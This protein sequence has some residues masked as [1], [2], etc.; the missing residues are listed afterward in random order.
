[1]KTVARI[2]GIISFLVAILFCVLSIHRAE[3]D[4]KDI[5]EDLTQ[6]NSQIEQFR[7]QVKGTEGETKTYLDGELAKAEKMIADSPKESTY[8]IVQIFI[9][10]LIALSLA[11]V[12]LLFS[13]KPALVTQLLVGAVVVTLVVYFA[14]PDIERGEYSG[15][16]SRT[17]AL[18][19]GIPVIVAGLF[20]LL[21]ARKSASAKVVVAI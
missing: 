21:A 14:S 4:K 8:L 5:A 1:M 9:G 11:F 17:L 15:L 12:V 2:F 10:V 13:K 18:M 20:A 7:Q 6:A 16:N 3:L 19:S